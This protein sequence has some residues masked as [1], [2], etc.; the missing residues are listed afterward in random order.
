MNNNR[1]LSPVAVARA[2]SLAPIFGDGMG[3][4]CPQ[5][6]DLTAAPMRNRNHDAN[7]THAGSAWRP[8]IR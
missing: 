5:Q 6:V 4:V 1:W 3:Q 8:P 2:T 7:T